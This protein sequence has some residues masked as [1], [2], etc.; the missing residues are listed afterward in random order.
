MNDFVVLAL[1]WIIQ[2]EER[3]SNAGQ[4]ERYHYCRLLRLQSP[5]NETRNNRSKNGKQ[6]MREQE[7]GINNRFV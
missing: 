4:N 7:K 6:R 1:C 5:T 2:G 3:N